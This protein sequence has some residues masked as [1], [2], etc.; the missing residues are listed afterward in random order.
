MAALAGTVYLVGSGPGDPGL[1]TVRAVELLSTADVIV[2]D[3]LI[4]DGSLTLARADAEIIPVGKEGGGPSTPQDEINRIIVEQGKAGKSVVRFKGGDSF[5]FGRG[6]EEA[7]VLKSEGIPFEVVPAVTSG[8]AAPATAGIPVTQ[9]GMASA[10]ALVTGHE[11]PTKPETALDYEGLAAFPGTLVLYMG[12]K[13]LPQITASLI[14]AGRRADEP[15][16]LVM[17][18][19]LANQKA[20]TATLETLAEAGEAAGI[21]A[22]AITLIGEVAS[23]R[24]ELAWFEKRPLHGRR[25]A[26][27]RARAQ[28]GSLS[29]KLASLGAETV[30]VPTIRTEPVDVGVP[31]DP[32]GFDLLCVTSTNSVPLLLDRLRAGGLDARALAG[33]TV[34]AIGPGTAKALLDIGITADVVPPRSIAEALAEALANSGTQYSKAIIVRA[35]EARDVLPDAL[36]AAGTDVTVVPLYKTV[37]EELSDAERAALATADTVTFTS[38]STVRNLL[39]S[40]GGVEGLIGAEGKRPRLASIGP[41]TSE[42]LKANGLTP[43]IEATQHDVGGLVDALIADAGA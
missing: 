20:V 14:A 22:P 19:T 32:A 5:V 15:A 13:R 35:E 30:E 33:L 25:I 24:D 9:R 37:R 43:D 18:G 11:D 39:D 12:V 36:T 3:R 28:A 42:E 6:G 2:H 4:P 26:V 31:L 1:M 29:A 21:K 23:L 38:A 8:I 16:A 27:T 41:I 10:V 7:L 17:R 34:A 40:C